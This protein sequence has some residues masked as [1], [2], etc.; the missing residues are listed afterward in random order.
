VS[1]TPNT[2]EAVFALGAGSRMVGRS[3]YCDYPPEA[4]KL[5]S[6]GGYVDPSLEAILAL[7]PDLVVGARGPIGRSLVDKLEVR[8]TV[9]YFP[10][11]ES[12]EEIFA[13]I[14]GLAEHLDLRP[15]GSRL[16][17]SIRDR[18]GRVH[19]SVEG[20]PQPRTLLVFGQAPISV[21]G[22][23]SFPAEMLALAGCKNAVDSGSRYPTLGFE[24]ILG[25][26]PDLIID[27][28]MAGGRTAEPIDVK[29]AGWASVRAVREGRIVRLDDDR[30]LRPGPRLA[31]GVALLARHAHQGVQIP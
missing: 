18:L 26:D 24:T 16:V 7:R 15:E 28:T 5:P 25:L 21:A 3:R 17:D 2:T 22:P 4:S 13:M 23:G 8:G 6:V 10:P 1:I 31:E 29:R 14:V 27:A 30:I 9:C 20:R 11:T 12:V 19:K